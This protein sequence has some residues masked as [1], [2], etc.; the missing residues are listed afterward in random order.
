MKLMLRLYIALYVRL[1]YAQSVPKLLI[2][3]RH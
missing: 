1:T 2:L 3:Q